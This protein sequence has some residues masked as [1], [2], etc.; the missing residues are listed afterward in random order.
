VGESSIPSPFTLAFKRRISKAAVMM[1]SPNTPPLLL[2]ASANSLLSQHGELVLTP[3]Q[4]AAYDGSDPK[5]PLLLAV[6]GTI[7]DVSKG[8]HFY[9][10]G[11]TYRFFSG[12]DGTRAFVTGCFADDITPDLR[13]AELMF[14]PVDDPEIDSLYT[15]GELKKLK[16]RERRMARKEVEGAVAHWAGFFAKSKKYQRVGRVVGQEG[17]WQGEVRK[18]CKK[19]EEG[20]P[21]R[22]K[23]ERYEEK[24]EGEKAA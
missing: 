8:R 4:L 12:H 16:E 20:R 9:G 23:P 14:T 18:L 13:G 24:K 6:N 19:A 15:K 1:I 7:Y 2:E 10:P 3:L 22:K 11:G 17:E 5:K 21:K